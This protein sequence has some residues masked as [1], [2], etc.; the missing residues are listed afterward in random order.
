MIVEGKVVKGV[1]HFRVRMTDYADVFERVTGE[2]LFPGTLNV[3]VAEAIPIRVDFRIEGGEINEPN[4]DLLFERCRINGIDA[5]RI[6]PS[7]AQGNGGH[8]DHI[9]EIAC[10][11]RIPNVEEGSAVKVEVFGNV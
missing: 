5:Y 8:G 3:Q 11:K 4:Q 10:S 9:L 7:D 1:G 6:R 2:K